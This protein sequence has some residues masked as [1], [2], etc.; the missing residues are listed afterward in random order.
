MADTSFPNFAQVWFSGKMRPSQGR[1]TGSIPVTCSGNSNLLIIR[2]EDVL[3]RILIP[4]LLISLII[5]VFLIYWFYY[6]AN[7]TSQTS[8]RSFCLEEGYPEGDCLWSKEAE[9]RKNL[10][11][12]VKDSGTCVIPQ[13]KHC[14]GEMC[15][16]YCWEK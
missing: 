11:F 14:S 13:S 8:C 1:D 15:H 9:S 4:L 10:G 5:I 3:K 6:R 7:Y 2:K 16:C 12:T